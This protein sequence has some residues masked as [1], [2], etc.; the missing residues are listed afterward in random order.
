MLSL[1]RC[2]II[3][4]IDWTKQKRKRTKVNYVCVKWF[5]EIEIE[6]LF[7]PSWLYFL[8]TPQRDR[9]GKEDKVVKVVFPTQLCP[10]IVFIFYTFSK[11]IIS[12]K[13]ITVTK[14]CK[15]R[16]RVRL[17]FKPERPNNSGDEWVDIVFFV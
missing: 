8:S 14:R 2:V 6:W 4:Q 11:E 7:I 3:F 12:T 16:L 9:K 10:F 1:S 17:P 5:L 15:L 13:T